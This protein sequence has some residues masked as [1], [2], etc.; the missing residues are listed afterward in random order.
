VTAHSKFSFLEADRLHAIPE[1]LER[2]AGRQKLA[3]LA[4]EN[5]A[6]QCTPLLDAIGNKRI[7]EAELI[8]V[9]AG[10]EAKS[11]EIVEGV[12][13][14]L[15]EQNY[16]RN[17]LI[18]NLGGGVVTDLGGFVASIF[19]RGVS[20]IN[21]PTSLLGMVDASIGGKTAVNLAHS[22]NQ[23]GRF[24]FPKHSFIIPEFLKTLPA[25]E[26]KSGYAEMLKHALLEDREQWDMLI[27]KG[28]S[29]VGLE[30]IQ[31]SVGVKEAI[32][33]RDPY[34]KNERKKLNL[35]H[36]I[37][38]AFEALFHGRGKSRSHGHCVAEGMYIE[39]YLSEMK[40]GLDPALG[41]QIRSD[42][43][44]HFEPFALG[45]NDSPELLRYLMQDKKNKSGKMRFSL[46]KDFALVQF[47]VEVSREEVDRAL[48]R[49]LQER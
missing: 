14:N 28:A 44:Q 30:E 32:C 11:L 27:Q 8:V 49:Y 35:G 4:D 21:L 2:R 6:E 39:S 31:F 41:K 24:H 19:K 36:N 13:E 1:W 34:E 12:C 45:P 42:L 7:S 23:I 18:M 9:P 46:L 17:T 10:E 43:R 25:G 33:E 47:D 3:I 5:T 40:K 26:K 38:H 22:K 37:G 48:T 15:L 20:Y 29:L 16:D